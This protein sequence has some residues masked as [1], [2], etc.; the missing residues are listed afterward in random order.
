M[1]NS[2][3]AAV[4]AYE[5]RRIDDNTKFEFRTFSGPTPTLHRGRSLFLR[6]NAGFFAHPWNTM[7]RRKSFNG[8]IGERRGLRLPQMTPLAPPP[9]NPSKS[10]K[11]ELSVL[12]D[13][14]LMTE[15][16]HGRERRYRLV[17]AQLRPVPGLDGVRCAVLG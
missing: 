9:M 15:R 5:R 3:W 7:V 14:G 6:G 12:L 11:L 10:A 1:N 8:F 16:R 4:G 2:Q 17:P 13:A